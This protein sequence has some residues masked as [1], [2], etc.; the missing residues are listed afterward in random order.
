MKKDIVL[1]L[2]FLKRSLDVRG[3]LDQRR[4]QGAYAPDEIWILL[5]GSQV[6]GESK[7]EFVHHYEIKS[8]AQRCVNILYL[9][10]SFL[11]LIRIKPVRIFQ[12]SSDVSNVWEIRN[13]Q[14]LQRI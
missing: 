5:K 7:L 8:C 12:I 3:V 2:R 9:K 14:I 1:K 6:K 13:F 11:T 10:V 4:A